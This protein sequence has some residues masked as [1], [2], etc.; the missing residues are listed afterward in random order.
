MPSTGGQIDSRCQR[1]IRFETRPT[2]EIELGQGESI[3]A[4]TRAYL[5]NV[6]SDEVANLRAPVGF[7]V[8]RFLKQVEFRTLVL[9]RRV[10]YRAHCFTPHAQLVSSAIPCICY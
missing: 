2:L 3:G 5:K 1:S 4:D 6:A 8:A 7:P 9:E 10:C